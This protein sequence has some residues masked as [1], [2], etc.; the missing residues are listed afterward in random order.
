MNSRLPQDC[1]S[2]LADSCKLA[3]N[4]C[5]QISVCVM[6]HS[7]PRETRTW[8]ARIDFYCVS[9]NMMPNS[10]SANTLQYTISRA[11]LQSIVPTSS[12]TCLMFLKSVTSMRGPNGMAQ[13][14]GGRATAST[15]R[16]CTPKRGRR[17]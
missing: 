16:Y 1:A 10:D 8:R 3:R 15:K 7:S 6:G 9:V 17:Q 11:S 14:Q 4:K 5:L 2:H 13:R 12:L